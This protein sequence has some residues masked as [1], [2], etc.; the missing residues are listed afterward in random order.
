MQSLYSYILCTVCSRVQRHENPRN[1]KRIKQ[2][3]KEKKKKYTTTTKYTKVEYMDGNKYIWKR[4]ECRRNKYKGKRQIAIETSQLKQ[5]WKEP[6]RI[7]S[8]TYTCNGN[9]LLCVRYKLYEAIV[10]SFLSYFNLA[11]RPSLSSASSFS[12]DRV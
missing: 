5:M 7:I 12:S 4:M 11:F 2:K 6:R 3:F 1:Q 9:G 8:S 10:A